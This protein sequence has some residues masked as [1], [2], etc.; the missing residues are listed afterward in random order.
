MIIKFFTWFGGFKKFVKEMANPTLS[1][2]P[3]LYLIKILPTS[4]ILTFFALPFIVAV[5]VAVES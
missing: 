5:I 1:V 3:Y 2:Y 4:K